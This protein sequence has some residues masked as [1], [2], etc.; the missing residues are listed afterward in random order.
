MSVMVVYDTMGELG[1]TEA[2]VGVLTGIELDG[3]TDGVQLGR[4]KV[5][6]MLPEPP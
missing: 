4:V 6:L 1:G 3:V 2:V 5:P